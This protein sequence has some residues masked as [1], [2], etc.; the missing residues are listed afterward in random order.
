MDGIL[1]HKITC[2]CECKN[3]Q[4]VKV[5]LSGRLCHECQHGIGSIQYA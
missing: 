5:Q 3:S 1:D 4:I 2:S